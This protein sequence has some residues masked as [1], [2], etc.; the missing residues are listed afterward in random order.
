MNYGRGYGAVI[1]ENNKKLSILG[2]NEEGT[3][4]MES[5]FIEDNCVAGDPVEMK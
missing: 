2:F 3:I 1:H 5:W 4:Y